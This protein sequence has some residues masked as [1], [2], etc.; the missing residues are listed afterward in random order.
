MAACHDH[1]DDLC[2]DL[3]RRLTRPNRPQVGAYDP[4]P[5]QESNGNTRGLAS[6]TLLRPLG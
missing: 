3:A 5:S 6:E 4:C 1:F 2:L